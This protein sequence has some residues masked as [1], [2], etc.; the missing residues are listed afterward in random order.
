MIATGGAIKTKKSIWYGLDYVYKEGKWKYDDQEYKL[1][2]PNPEGDM[3]EIKQEKAAFSRKTLR[4]TDG[5]D[6]G[7]KEHLISLQISI[8][9]G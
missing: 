7:Y 5:P 4:M 2:I 3:E 8:K 1:C 9:S 6:K